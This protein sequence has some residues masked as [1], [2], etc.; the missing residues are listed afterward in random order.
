LYKKY[1]LNLLIIYIIPVFW[2]SNSTFF[3][4][5]F[6]A[7]LTFFPFNFCRANIF[8]LLRFCPCRG[9]FYIQCYFQQTF[10]TY[11]NFV[12]INV[13]NILHFFQSTFFTF[14]R[15]VS[16]WSFFIFYVLSRSAFFYLTLCPIRRCFFRR[17]VCRWFLFLFRPFVGESNILVKQHWN[18]VLEEF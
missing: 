8:Y 11:Q 5:A 18:I 13:F 3:S 6:Y 4:S 1:N 7:L 16:S 14:R 2:Y 9:F 12:P 15:F 10:I 17:V